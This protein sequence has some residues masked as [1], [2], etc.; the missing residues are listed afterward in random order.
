MAASLT[1][2]ARVRPED[3]PKSVGLDFQD[4]SFKSR[5]GDA[6]LSGWIIPMHSPSNQ[7]WVFMIHGDATNRSDAKTKTLGLARALRERGFGI[8]MLDMRGRGNS[9]VMML[10]S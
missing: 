4:V 10:S 3:T 8:F 5:R 2:T 7:S 9:H 1:K 6:R